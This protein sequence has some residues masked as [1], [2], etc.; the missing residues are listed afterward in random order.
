MRVV[1][2]L[3]SD[4]DLL[5][6]MKRIF[7]LVNHGTYIMYGSSDHVAPVCSETEQLDASIVDVKK[8]LYR[9]K[10]LF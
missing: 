8:F 1:F 2:K 9:S 4:P 10:Y 5:G 3:G 6:K 7:R